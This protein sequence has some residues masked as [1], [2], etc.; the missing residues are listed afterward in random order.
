MYGW[1]IRSHKKLLLQLFIHALISHTIMTS[2]N[3][4]SLPVT[5][6]LW[7]ESTGHWLIPLTQASEAELDVF[8]WCASEETVK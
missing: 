6:I 4:H 3:R 2:S 5:G 7:G 8:L 1:G